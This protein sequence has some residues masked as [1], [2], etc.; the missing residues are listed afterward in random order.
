MAAKEFPLEPREVPFIETP[1]RKIITKIPAPGS[2]S[3]L[4]KLRT[5]ESRS[6]RGQAPVVWQKA[7]GVNIEDGY[8][9]KWLDWSSG[10]LVTSVGHGHPKIKKALTDYL[11]TEAPLHSYCFPNEARADLAEKL[12]EISP[13]E[14]NKVFLLT[15]GSEA[16]EVSIKLART[17]GIRINSKK[18]YIVSFQGGFHGRTYGAQ[19]AG[20][21][22]GGSEWI[23]ENPYFLQ[24]PFPGSIEVKN[25]SFDVFTGILQKLNIAS[26]DIAGVIVETFQGREAKLMPVEY[27]RSLRKWCDEN[28]AALIFDE[29]QAGFGRTGKLF[30]FEHYGVVPDMVCCGKGITS[31]LPLSAVIGRAEYMDQ[32]GPGEMTSTHTGSPLPAVASIASIDVMLEEG[33]IENAANMGSYLKGELIEITE[34]YKRRINIGG[35]GLVVGMLFFNNREDLMP[36]ADTAFKFCEQCFLSGNLFFAPVG[37]GYGA[38][39][40]CPPLCITKEAIDDGLYGKAGIKETLDKVMR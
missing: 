40:F 35:V 36:D 24:V 10:V 7:K 1:Y 2:I 17:H 28:N 3:I 34:P 4:N 14:L 26:C 19:L 11:K 5:N 15:T 22:L 12:I 9:N 27:A 31:S 21:V 39:K 33:L 29:V 18:R 16:A 20:G 37:K 30:A 13:S 23:D 25:K 32:Y 6:M 8:G 38:I